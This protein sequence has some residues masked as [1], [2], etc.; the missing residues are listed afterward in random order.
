MKDW[1][2]TFRGV[3]TA[4]EYDATSS[5][6]SQMYATR[7]DQATWLLL[8]ALGV[9]P[10]SVRQEGLRIAVIRQNFQ[11]LRELRGGE[12]VRIRS[13]FLTVGEKYFRMLHQ[14]YDDDSNKMVATC[15]IVAVRASGATDE[16]VKLTRELRERAEAH[17]V[18]R[19]APD[20]DLPSS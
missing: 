19:N 10:S 18:T 1:I 3:V 11:F 2:N 5:M 13:G 20:P 6:N 16:S 14:M 7:F 4:S 8:Q 15:D 12:L 17:L 9:T